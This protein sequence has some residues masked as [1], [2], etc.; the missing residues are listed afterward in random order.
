MVNKYAKKDNKMSYWTP[1]NNK[2][3]V[4]YRIMHGGE[5]TKA[6]VE[7]IKTD[8]IQ[9]GIPRAKRH[10]LFFYKNPE[11][12]HYMHF[13]KLGPKTKT[14]FFSKMKKIW[15]TTILKQF[16]MYIMRDHVSKFDLPLS[17]VFEIWKNK[18][19][20]W[21]LN[22][23]YLKYPPKIYFHENINNFQKVED[24]DIQYNDLYDVT[25]SIISKEYYIPNEKWYRINGQM[26]YNPMIPSPD[27]YIVPDFTLN[28]GIEIETCVKTIPKLTNFI[29]TDDSSIRCT[30]GNDD[31]SV[32][33]ILKSYNNSEN[34][35]NLLVDIEAIV[36]A[37]QACQSFTCGLH[38]HISSNNIPYNTYGIIFLIN[39]IFDWNKTYQQQFI[40]KYLYKT[41]II[42]SI[43]HMELE[44]NEKF[45]EAALAMQGLLPENTLSAKN[46]QKLKNIQHFMIEKIYQNKMFV[47]E[48][49]MRQIR[50][51]SQGPDYRPLLTIVHDYT[52]IHLEFRGL[53][54]W[55]L[56]NMI[57]GEHSFVKHVHETFY[58]VLENTNSMI[59]KSMFW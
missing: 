3:W 8:L 20:R 24:I 38:F 22:I 34:M 55:R 39:Y 53:M 32:E 25:P 9:A 43:K 5:P 15:G 40:N 6:E 1:N 28:V 54:P 45:K 49:Y 46:I 33:F 50:L 13:F 51:L 2:G 58:E 21:K 37:Q 17:K 7:D 59:K 12:R 30:S 36:D 11:T 10:V 27:G 47:P 29:S 26:I 16:L 31:E 35:G 14:R 41:N 18:T 52:F 23:Q 48:N 42:K 19:E 44:G 4:K 56:K 57:I